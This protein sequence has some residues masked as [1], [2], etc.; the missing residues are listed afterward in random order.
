[1]TLTSAALS[2]LEESEAF[3]LLIGRI[4]FSRPCQTGDLRDASRDVIQFRF[5]CKTCLVS[6]RGPSLNLDPTNLSTRRE[7]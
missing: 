6:L 2:R 4:S 5:P 7:V 3:G 1:M